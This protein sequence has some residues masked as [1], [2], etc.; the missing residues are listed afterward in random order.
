MGRRVVVTGLGIICSIGTNV[1][2][3][4]ANCLSGKTNICS[5]PDGWTDFSNL[6]SKFWSPLKEV[7][8][9][10]YGIKKIEQKNLDTTSLLAI[11]STMQALSSSKLK[12]YLNDNKKNTYSIQGVD[13]K[14][15]G[16]FIGTGVGGVNTAFS[17]HS[18]IVLT[19]LINIVNQMNN[20]AS[21]S[22][23]CALAELEEK[24][25][26]PKRFNP[27]SIPKIMPNACS[28]NIGIKFGITG[29]NNTYC[30]SC[31][32][33]TVAIG[34]AY[35]AIKN[36]QIDVAISGGTEY[37]FDEFG[38]IFYAFDKVGALATGDNILNVNCPFDNKRSGFLFSEGG[39]A[40]LILEELGHALDRGA[41]ILAEILSYSESSDAHS[42]M[43][44][45][46]SGTNIK[47]MLYDCLDGANLEPGEVRYINAHG[48]GTYVNDE[49]ETK[50]IEEIF[51]RE[52]LINSTKSLTGHTIGASGAIEAL[53][54][55]M[56]IFNNTTHICKNLSNPIRN[57]NYVTE[58]RKYPIKTAISQSFGFGGHNAALA[59]KSY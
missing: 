14:K 10:L 29:P 25:S 20:E 21:D 47:C 46:E 51:G 17:A 11:S 54:T 45:E 34:Y 37:M 38:S 56:S 26:I 55:V 40:V 42:I 4:W 16:V 43:A 52:V 22:I 6:K 33:G 7:D 2:D 13:Q 27:Y 36:S 23:K 1:E 3:F 24:F 32:S 44:I 30:S 41:P 58:V 15:T 59:F 18:N 57:L 50:I 12:Y 31:A 8:Y 49:I 28:S 48:T 53:V 5:I 9:S 35:K 19:S 39:A